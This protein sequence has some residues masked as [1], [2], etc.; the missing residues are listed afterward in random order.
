[1]ELDRN[2]FSSIRLT[3]H[4]GKYYDVEAVDRLL[5]DIRRKAD[6]L[7]REILDSREKLAEAMKT[8]DELRDENSNLLLEGQTLNQEILSLREQL[9]EA[10]ERQTASVPEKEEPE[11]FQIEEPVLK[12]VSGEIPAEEPVSEEPSK[13]AVQEAAAEV[14]EKTVEAAEAVKDVF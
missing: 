13:E 1:M 14:K 8:A 2:Y 11:M 7:N 9:K 3:A 6:I 10:T 12:T 5:V 4:R